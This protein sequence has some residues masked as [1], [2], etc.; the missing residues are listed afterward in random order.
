MKHVVSHIINWQSEQRNPLL[1]GYCF[2]NAIN[3][4][5]KTIPNKSPGLNDIDLG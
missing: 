2:S 4:D 3:P 5:T 1:V